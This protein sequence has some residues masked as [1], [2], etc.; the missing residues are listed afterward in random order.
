MEY[1]T[2]S[3]NSYVGVFCEE[4]I[5]LLEEVV[6]NLL[7]LE[8]GEKKVLAA[9]FRCLHT[10]KGGAGVL[11]FTPIMRLAHVM[12][13]TMEKLQKDQILLSQE[14]VEEVFE[15]TESLR[16]M[17]EKVERGENVQERPDLEERLL[18]IARK[19]TSAKALSS[20]ESSQESDEVLKELFLMKEELLI[21]PLGKEKIEALR[22]K[23]LAL[24]EKTHARGASEAESYVSALIRYLELVLDKEGEID[25]GSEEFLEGLK[26]SLQ[27]IQDLWQS[28]ISQTQSRIEKT[29]TSF[30]EKEVERKS[31]Y[32]RVEERKIDT[33]TNLVEELMMVRG[34]YEYLLE[35]LK[36]YSLPS[37]LIKAFRDN[38]R[39]LSRNCEELQK[40]LF[41]LRLVPAKFLFQ[42]FPKVARDIALQKQKKIKLVT[43]GENTEV[44]KKVLDALSGAMLHLVRNACDHGIESPQERVASGKSE[45]GTVSLKAWHKGSFVYLEVSDDGRGLDPEKILKK[46]QELGLVAEGASPTKEEIFNLI[47]QPGFSTADSVSEISGRGVGMDAVKAAVEE[48]HGSV[49]I[50][51]IFGKGTSFTLKVP[52]R[53]GITTALLVR[54]NGEQYALPVEA[55]ANITSLTKKQIHFARKT[56]VFS[57]QGRIISLCSL[58]YLLGQQDAAFPE[59]ARIVVATNGEKHIGL[60]V[61]EV[62][63]RHNMV[64]KPLPKVL[65]RGPFTGS[66][67][68]GDGRV[69]FVVDPF[70]VIQT[71]RSS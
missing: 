52:V 40:S 14:V 36:E 19:T 35:K 32:L 8:R 46:A 6:Q 44:D 21:L 47:F 49:E 53:L 30:E 1:S 13:D 37:E 41:S 55:V 17:I 56:P 65:S 63:G 60:A 51:S 31:Q 5:E 67:I 64:T 34:N 20:R 45:E 58:A 11:E 10:I 43:A 57:F 66:A 25:T 59:E 9:I 42:R 16:E 2:S 69:I 61:D 68:L 12:E 70:K 7:K 71:S 24:E 4:S 33:F 29:E 54:A 39:S 15:A 18:F 22:Q 26:V 28:S 27:K 38:H 50:R 48:L 23:L 62:L 3:M